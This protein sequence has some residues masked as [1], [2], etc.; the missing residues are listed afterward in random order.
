MSLFKINLKQIIIVNNAIYSIIYANYGIIITFGKILYFMVK[1]KLA[2]RRL[3][4]NI[5][6]EK[7]GDLLGIT[8]SQY[9]RRETGVTKLTKKEW[10]KMAQILDTTLENIY[11]PEDGMYIINNEN[12][13][14]NYSGS[15]NH[16]HQLPDHV[17]ETMRKYIAKLEE[18]NK[19]LTEEI[20]RLKKA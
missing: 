19:S 20:L 7:M 9:N 8:Q 17:L 4:K 3:E 6:Q 15:Q 1:Q 12:A 2:N 5:T 16:F 13:N 11:E 14:G 18:E 10:D